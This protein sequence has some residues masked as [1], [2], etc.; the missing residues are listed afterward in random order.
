MKKAVDIIINS[1]IEIP[2]TGCSYC[3]EGCPMHIAI[4]K[5][6]SLYN[7]DKQEVATKSWRPQGEYYTRLTHT[8]GKASECIG[9]GQCEAACPQHLPIIENLQKVAEYFEK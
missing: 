7:A 6:F 8:F 3:T 2:C 4:P 9:C 5:Y 1:S